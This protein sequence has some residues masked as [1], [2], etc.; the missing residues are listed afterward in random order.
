MGEEWECVM[1]SSSGDGS[2][3]FC[4]P[5]HCPGTNI[6]K[7]CKPLSAIP[8]LSV[9][10]STPVLPDE[11]ADNA[12]KTP[13]LNLSSCCS[14]IVPQ[15]AD[16]EDYT[17]NH[18]IQTAINIYECIL[19]I[20]GALMLLFVV[21]GG[22]VLMASHGNADWISL[23]KKMISAAI[24]GGVLAFATYAIIYFA[25]TAV[26]ANFSSGLLIQP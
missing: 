22:I 18:I 23:G 14:Q 24:V 4:Q 7:C 11:P 16:G 8:V 9:A 19:C 25:V 12:A 20:V 13:A 10:Q 26:G 21:L 5:F 2:S 17:L 15:L 3:Y 6:Y 1:N